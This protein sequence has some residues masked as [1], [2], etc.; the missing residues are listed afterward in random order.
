MRGCPHKSVLSS[1][2]PRNPKL[3]L[4]EHS[5]V[6]R[7][8]E[9]QIARESGWRLLPLE[10]PGPA[11]AVALLWGY[12]QNRRVEEIVGSLLRNYPETTTN[13]N[14]MLGFFCA[15]QAF[16]GDGDVFALKEELLHAK[17]EQYLNRDHRI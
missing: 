4:P 3:Y 16:V 9:E 17:F 6:R 10:P 14:M 13:P 11:Q 2:N 1:Y 8:L 15:L 7:E 5:H 12:Y